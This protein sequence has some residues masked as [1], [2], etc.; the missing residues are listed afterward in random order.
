MTA[1][2]EHRPPESSRPVLRFVLVF[3]G[4]LVLF[5][6][7]FLSLLVESAPLESYLELCAHITGR[8]LAALGQEVSVRGAEVTL[9]GA[10]FKVGPACSGL[11][12]LAMLAIAILAFPSTWRAK[13]PGL[14]AAVVVIGLLNLV[15]IASLCLIGA[16]WPAAFE[17][18][19]LY[20]WPMALIL[21]SIALWSAWARR[22]TRS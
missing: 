21:C 3:A 22:A 11:Q 5:Q 2:P 1:Q 8:V 12:P 17:L 15:R 18:S 10:A 16:H 6:L 19:H 7:L 20:L 4:G 9:C 14:V 13:L